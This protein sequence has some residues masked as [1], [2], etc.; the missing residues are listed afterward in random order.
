MFGWFKTKPRLTLAT[1]EERE[2][3]LIK[4]HPFF[5]E[6]DAAFHTYLNLVITHPRLN[7]GQLEEALIRQGI[8]PGLAED[9][10]VFVPLAWGREVVEGLGVQYSPLV[11]VHSL[12]DGSEWEQ[13][14]TYEMVY[15][16]ARAMIG[17]YR[18]KERNE[19]FQL[20]S[21][22]SAEVDCINNALFAGTSQEDLRECKLDPA[23][24]PLRRTAPASAPTADPGSFPVD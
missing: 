24:V 17:L 22:R 15:A 11:R 20:V 14:L 6:V 4:L 9:C 12:I 23:L 2:A 18:T 19:V 1:T 7:E 5:R 13:P 10:V 8:S 16:W 3:L 21:V